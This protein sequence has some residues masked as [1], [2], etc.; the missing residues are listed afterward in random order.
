MGV[1]YMRRR[2]R[3]LLILVRPCE[4]TTLDSDSDDEDEDLLLRWPPALLG[5]RLAPSVAYRPLTTSS[6]VGLLPI[7]VLI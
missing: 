1:I 4:A 6:Q 7:G 2:R 5:L 3:L